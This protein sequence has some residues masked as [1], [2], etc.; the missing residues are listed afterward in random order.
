MSKDKVTD[1]L[2]GG[3][4]GNLGKLIERLGSW[5]RRGKS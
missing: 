4:F 5:P 1:L 3:L 2:A